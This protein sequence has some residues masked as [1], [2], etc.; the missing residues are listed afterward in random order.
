VA[1]AGTAPTV[2]PADGL[3]MRRRWLAAALAFVLLVRLFTLG[4]YPLMDTSEA[5]YGEIVRIMQI[6]GNWVTPQET[7][8]TPFWAKPPLYA[9]LGTVSID[10]FGLREWALRLP[11]LL[12]G[13]GVLLLCHTWSCA[14]ARRAAPPSPASGRSLAP[15]LSCL[16]LATTVLFF[17]GFGAVM[18]DPALCLC[19]AWMMV[20][21]QRA[22]IDASARA[23]WRYGFFAAAGVAM[24][25][26]G[27]VAMLYVG[28]PL[29]VWVPWCGRW[30]EAWAALPWVRGSLLS[31]VLF[32]P[33]Y[34][35]AEARTPGFLNYFLIGEH[36]MRYLRPGW[37]GDRYGTA[38]VEPIG[39]VWAYLAGAMGLWT[40]A[41]AALLRP[42][43]GWLGRA[44]GYLRDD[45]TR[46]AILTALLPLVV[47]TFARNVIWT[48]A[49]PSLLPLSVLLGRE[50]AQ[51]ADRPGRWGRA[52]LVLAAGS[53]VV[54]TVGAILWAPM[55][56]NGS[57]Y[58]L[59]V[60]AWQGRV[61]AEP[62]ALV[63]WGV[64]T[65]ASLRFYSRGQAR[66][67]A[68]LP[69]ELAGLS[70]GDRL[71]VAI[72]AERLPALR[73][74]AYTQPQTLDLHV[75]EQVKHALIAEVVRR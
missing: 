75:V 17:I 71:Y 24:L 31:L 55:R 14:L 15:L 30:R 22:V 36:L 63:F 3:I 35:W 47:F 58:A 74:L 49:M 16:V 73:Q 48:Y 61:A 7:V 20:S 10:L 65:P 19:T 64:R 32:V 53:I 11:S 1:A 44:R 46:W 40:I 54:L 50:L 59:P 39:T 34:V 9:W 42:A 69:T 43:A 25:A 4:A 29:L 56:A 28:L 13:L 41:L 37:T 5:R 52:V 51:R 21:F 68:D 8:G 38:H 6:T 67:T 33:W 2:S 66:A 12:C 60:A 72:D 27:P 62:G 23:L 26:K 57:S 70:P 18:T 45:A